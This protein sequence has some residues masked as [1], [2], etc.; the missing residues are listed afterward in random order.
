MPKADYLRT[1]ANAAAV[2]ETLVSDLLRSNRPV[3]QPD[4]DSVQIEPVSTRHI[5]TICRSCAMSYDAIIATLK[6]L[7][8]HGIV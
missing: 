7:R 5:M 3:G 6:S 8:L 4:W 1:D 2:E